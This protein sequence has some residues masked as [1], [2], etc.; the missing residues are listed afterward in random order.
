M[1]NFKTQNILA[2]KCQNTVTV[3]CLICLHHNRMIIDCLIQS[4]DVVF[5]KT[6]NI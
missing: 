3:C 6:E 4:K 2:V 1:A 5:F